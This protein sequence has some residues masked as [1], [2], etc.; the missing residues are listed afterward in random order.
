MDICNNKNIIPY[1]NNFI[2]ITWLPPLALANLAGI[3]PPRLLAPPLCAPSPTAPRRHSSFSLAPVR[4]RSR[5]HCLLTHPDAD[6]AGGLTRFGD[7]DLAVGAAITASSRIPTR[8]GQAA[9]PV[10]TTT[11]WAGEAWP[12]RG[13]EGR[14]EVRDVGYRRR[15]T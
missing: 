14:R 10:S 7:D 2:I 4:R 5:H 6:G 3:A 11:T 15:Y 8:M 9:W 1:H 12:R 13:V